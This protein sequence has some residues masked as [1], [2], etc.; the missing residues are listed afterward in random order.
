[1]EITNKIIRKK[2]DKFDTLLK[3]ECPRSHQLSRAGVW[4]LD[5]NVKL[6]DRHMHTLFILLYDVVRVLSKSHSA[7][8][9]E[10]LNDVKR[11]VDK[12]ELIVPRDSEPST[13]AVYWNVLETDLTEP[14]N[15]PVE[16]RTSDETT[17]KE[18]VE[19]VIVSNI[20]QSQ[21]TERRGT[22]SNITRQTKDTI[23]ATSTSQKDVSG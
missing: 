2:R 9:H 21:K 4:S 20:H 1:M 7:I 16:Y 22:T 12:K 11:K 15:D 14:D 19:S 6:S 17:T 10:L 13:D 5:A 8:A 3:T 23:L 18:E